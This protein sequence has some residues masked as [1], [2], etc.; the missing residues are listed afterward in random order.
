MKEKWKCG[1][2]GLQSGHRYDGGCK[3]M[4]KTGYLLKKEEVDD[5]RIKLRHLEHDIR[6]QSYTM[7]E[8]DTKLT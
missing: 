1:Y 6:L 2:C 4:S 8:H 5:F 3:L 7:P